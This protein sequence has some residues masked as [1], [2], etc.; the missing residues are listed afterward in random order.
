MIHD[1]SLPTANEFLL[2]IHDNV[3]EEDSEWILGLSDSLKA[4]NV[5]ILF[6]SYN[7]LFYNLASH[8][9]FILW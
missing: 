8:G 2:Q 7:V 1:P 9:T 3:C 5:Y 4:L 6:V